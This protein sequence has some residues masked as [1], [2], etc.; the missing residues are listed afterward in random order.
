MMNDERFVL[1][2]FMC[3]SLAIA[4]ADFWERRR[5]LA[6][7]ERMNSRSLWRKIRGEK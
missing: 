7:V 6:E 5:H 3:L 4:L 1:L 2:I